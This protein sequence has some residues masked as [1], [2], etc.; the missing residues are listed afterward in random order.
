MPLWL[1][2]ILVV[3]GIGGVVALIHALGHSRGLVFGSE[4]EA[5]QHWL[6]NTGTGATRA[7]LAPDGRAAL[8][9]GGAGVVW[10]MGADSTARPLDGAR[11]VADARGL[12]IRFPDPGAP[13]LRLPPETARAWAPLLED[14]A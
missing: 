11:F 4:A 3:A 13:A 14:A 8:I 5:L 6:R 9:D 2:C 1:L 10:A 7:T 12:T